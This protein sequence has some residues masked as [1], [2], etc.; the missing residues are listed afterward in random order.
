M[1]QQIKAYGEISIVDISDVGKLQAYITSNQ[2]SVVIY[3]PNATTK[4]TPD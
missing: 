2:P 3:D 1:A 4:Y